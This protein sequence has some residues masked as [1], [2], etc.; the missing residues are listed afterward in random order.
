MYFLG[1]DPTQQGPDQGAQNARYDYGMNPYANTVG[2]MGN[3]MADTGPVGSLHPSTFMMGQQNPYQQQM[4]Q[5]LMGAPT[6]WED[7]IGR[8]DL[9]NGQKSWMEQ[10]YGQNFAGQDPNAMA[11][12]QRQAFGQYQN[13]AGIAAQANPSLFNNNTG[14]FT[15]YA[16]QSGYNASI[17]PF[18]SGQHLL[19]STYSGSGPG[20]YMTNSTM[21]NALTGQSYGSYN[22]LTGE[23]TN[24]AGSVIQQGA[25]SPG[26]GNLAGSSY[27]QWL[28]QGGR[29]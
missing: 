24:G 23:M 10:Y 1:V 16:F 8:A 2:N 12:L 26:A 17:N 3:R 4:G 13:D 27:D 19:E 29:Y 11:G 6:S 9:G 28:K 14:I 20:R 15:P 21:K 22:P 7:L 25:F 5:S 18:E